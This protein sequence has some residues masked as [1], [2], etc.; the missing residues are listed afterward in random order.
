MPGI[1]SSWW[2]RRRR[3]VSGWAVG[4]N[5]APSWLGERWAGLRLFYLT[6]SVA[7]VLYSTMVLF[8]MVWMGTIGV[9]CMFGTEVEDNVSTNFR[10]IDSQG[11]EDRP[12]RGDALLSIN[13]TDLTRG[14]YAAYIAAI[15][16]LSGR[17]GDSVNVRWMNGQTGRLHEASAEVRF[18]PQ[19]SYIWSFIW[20]L[21]EM[22][23]FAVGARVFWRRPNDDSARLFFM[24]CIVTVGA[25]M[26]GYHWTEIVGQPWLIYPFVLVALLVPTVNLHFYLVFPRPNPLLLVH[27]RWVLGVLYGVPGAFLAALWGSMYASR[28]LRLRDATTQSSTALEL[29]RV[30]ALSYVWVAV[31][32]F[33]LCFLCL[34]F[35]YRRARHRGE[36]NQVKWILLATVASSVLIGYLMVQTLIDPSNL[37]RD[38]AAWPMFTVSLLYTIAHAFSITRY[39]LLQVDEIVNRSMAYFAFSV[40]A[41]LIYSGLLLI[42]GKLIGDRLTS[43]G[44]SWGAVV[45]TVSVI[46]VLFVS[47][48]ARGRF[49]RILDRRFF[50]EKYK[51]DQAMQ[52]MRLAVGSLVDRQT[53][54]KRLL[55]GTAEV[56]RLEWGALYL[57]EPEDGRFELAASHGPAPDEAV[58][59]A[60]H[61]LVTRLRQASSVRQSHSIGSAA[62]SDP[63]T[64]SM[65]ALGGEAACGVGGDGRLA[66]VL[67]LGP[68][69]SG[70]PYEDEEMAFLG[71]LSS[72]SA[73]ALHS[74]DIQ[75]TLE[76]LNHELR[77]KVDKIAEQQRRI[78][79]LQDQLRDRAERE[80]AGQPG[81][82]ARGDV[83][84][85]SNGLVE[86]FERMKGSSPAARRMM[87]MARKVAASSSAVLI[88][89][90][91]GTGK[92][93][94]AAAVHAASPRA[95]RP[96]VKVHCAALSQGLLESELFG[97]VKGAFTGADRDRMGRFEQADGGTLFLD[98]I[99][100]INLEVQTKLLRVL[101]ET[102]FER[103]GSSQS[104][105]VD[106]RIVAATHQ[107]LEALIREG[108]FRE[109]LYYRLN[110]ICL[111]TPALRER[112]EDVL[113]LAMH[114][115]DVYAARMGKV[116][117]YIEPEAVEALMA[118][119]WPGNIRELENTIER[120]VVL[121]D[122]PS[123]TADDLPP[124][125]RQ[126]IRRR[127]R[128][129]ASAAGVAPRAAAPTRG[130]APPA[131]APTIGRGAT[132][133]PAPVPAEGEDWGDEFS[134]YE[135]Q[136][137]VEAMEE[138]DG[139][140]SVAARLLGM[141][142]STF[143]S[144]LKKHGLA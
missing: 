119:D 50:R 104:L 85:D 100:D 36:R 22:L 34:V 115:L 46:V 45:A 102:S 33:G 74:A 97:H 3:N 29:I 60:D 98:E 99:G 101:Q 67:V 61:P 42:S 86:A 17:V 128:A 143:F 120:A 88:R 141:P 39:K 8:Q 127:Y 77:G 26:G 96:F 49:Q 144:K 129:R 51:F 10:W 110:V 63:A 107:D 16:G 123:L 112:R 111:T 32:F 140:K 105:R 117:T 14:D 70:M 71:A 92:E 62:A 116:L 56:L 35:S 114:F 44:T 59:E 80:T 24:L 139:N 137:L 132:S 73:M 125:V 25:F 122:G 84:K 133:G 1:G 23:I 131:A 47:E 79:I 75:E 118:H 89:G 94:L 19:S 38:S 68:K 6:C 130:L 55:E 53:L 113:E 121:A 57:A 9:R 18:M 31:F 106:V 20:F 65:I 103:V 69:R 81:G 28:W 138:A 93:L 64:D 87:N 72:V 11:R 124:E 82:A 91:S 4:A 12:R 52:K 54:G 109:D 5:K 66:G 83:R 48:L 78:L 142:R 2:R 7:V 108:R 90:E 37:G 58:L 30:L 15:R 40:T 27:R 136:R 95:A 76:T 41:G 43:L 135:R 126:P 134:S 13:G 21:Q